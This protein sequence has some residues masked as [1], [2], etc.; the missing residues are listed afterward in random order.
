M[1]STPG[2][3]TLAA[4]ARAANV[5][6]ATASK[7]LNGRAGVSDATRQRVHE[8]IGT[9]GYRPTTQRH[10]G[11]NGQWVSAVFDAVSAQYS[12]EILQSLLEVAA[13]RNVRLVISLSGPPMNAKPVDATAWADSLVGP[14]CLGMLFVTCQL[15]PA[16]V[17]ACESRGLP[18][19]AIDSYS[20]LTNGIVTVGSANFSGGLIATEH[21]IGMGHTRIGVITGASTS[22]FADERLHGYRAALV[23]AGLEFRPEL[24]RRG[25]FDFDTGFNLGGELLDTASGLTAIVAGCDASAVGVIGA[26]S[27]RGL[28]VPED[29]SVVGFDDTGIARWSSPPLT[30]VNQPIADIASTALRTLLDNAQDGRVSSPN[31]QL[32]TRLVERESTA[33]PRR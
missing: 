13:A 18:I 10:S 9:L 15:S 19:V 31:I 14:D 28:R 33:P 12:A 25:H 2:R 26:A 11:S 17:A 7:V 22:L 16:Q 32:T 24:I 30:T 6:I 5:S 21:L 23:N 27:R 1:E 3:T 4:V 8:V 29:L 20:L